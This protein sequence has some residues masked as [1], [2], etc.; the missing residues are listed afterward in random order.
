MSQFLVVVIVAVLLILG[1]LP[2]ALL[3]G[4]AEYT[5]SDEQAF[6][7]I[8]TIR[9]NNGTLSTGSNPEIYS[10]GVFNITLATQTRYNPIAINRSV[11]EVRM[12]GIYYAE[13][14]FGQGGFVTVTQGA[15]LDIVAGDVVVNVDFPKF[16]MGG[17]GGGWQSLPFAYTL[18][19]TFL[20]LTNTS[21]LSVTFECTASA[22]CNSS[23]FVNYGIYL[24]VDLQ[25]EH[26]I[27]SPNPSLR[28]SVMTLGL[29]SAVLLVFE[30]ADTK[31]MRE[32]S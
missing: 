20:D 11:S 4:K 13:T 9:D 30:T 5:Y 31:R 32:S 21:S 16:S 3:E 14:P 15:D 29:C 27:T 18:N 12:E 6:S 10:A 28:I 7:Q 26:V 1:A 8:V 24:G 23:Y 25:Y 19:R 2:Q 17:D 22:E